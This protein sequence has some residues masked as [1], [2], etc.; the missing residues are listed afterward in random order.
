MGTPAIAPKNLL[1]HPARK[2]DK[3]RVGFFSSVL[4]VLLQ[5]GVMLHVMVLEKIPRDIDNKDQNLALTSIDLL[6]PGKRSL[7]ASTL[8]CILQFQ[9]NKWNGARAHTH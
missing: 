1:L 8:L 7:H 6:K 5:E 2:G 9:S 4:W 3:K